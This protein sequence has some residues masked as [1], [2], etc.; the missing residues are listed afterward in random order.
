MPKFKVI[1]DTNLFVS[2]LAFGGMVLDILEMIQDENLILVMSEEL[3]EEVI[4]KLKNKFE[5]SSEEIEDFLIFAQAFAL[6]FEPNIKIDVC[7]DTKDNFLLE[8]AQVS[9][10]DF[11]L[12][13]DK[14]LLVLDNW[15]NTQICKPENFLNLLRTQN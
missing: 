6:W 4:L 5:L 12:T 2:A 11:L 9:N 7:R 10:S 14:D 15:K 13:R 1:L 8:L 3:E